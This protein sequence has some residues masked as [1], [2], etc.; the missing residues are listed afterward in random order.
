MSEETVRVLV[1]CRPLNS[2]ERD[3]QCKI[4][5]EIDEGSG[6]VRLLRPDSADPPKQF[7]FDGAYDL[8]SNTKQIYEDLAFPLVE[9]VLQGY[10]ATVFAYG[11][12]GK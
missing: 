2:R 10:N 3:L 8:N 12:T 11:Q 5:V 6:T 7:T 4:V 1:R 9:N